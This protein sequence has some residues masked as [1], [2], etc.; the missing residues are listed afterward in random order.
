MTS[1]KIKHKMIAIY[2]LICRLCGK[3][4]PYFVASALCILLSA[5]ATRSSNHVTDQLP[6]SIVSSRTTLTH[7]HLSGAIAAKRRHKGWLA[8]IDWQQQGAN[9]YLIHLFGPLG[10]GAVLIEK[11]DTLVTY[12]DGPQRYSAMSAEA[13]LQQQTGIQLPITNL[14]YW[15]RGVPAPGPIVTAIH[16]KDQHLLK[17]TQ[18]GY[19]L[20]YADYQRV[21]RL[22]LP[23]KILLQGR[24]IQVKLV[25]KHWIIKD[26]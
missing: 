4:Q 25:I 12:Q 3:N 13:L 1:Y 16:D 8:S 21:N 14:Y 26:A 5:C 2:Y 10:G 6:Q 24:D 23:T 20:T 11:K 19:R 18:A 7:W 9:Q 22:F 17:L 15:V